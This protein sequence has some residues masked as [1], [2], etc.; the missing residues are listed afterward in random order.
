VSEP[1]QTQKDLAADICFT[2]ME[3]P[4]ERD[5][6]VVARMIAEAW[7]EEAA[8]LSFPNEDP[9]LESVMRTKGGNE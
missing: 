4:T 3:L 2:V 8:V 6:D 7:R 9:Y 5:R 1:T